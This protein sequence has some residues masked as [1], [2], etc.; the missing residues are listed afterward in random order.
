MQIEKTSAKML[1]MPLVPRGWI[2]RL[3]ALP[4]SLI[5]LYGATLSAQSLEIK[6]VDGRNGRPVVGSAS[7]VNVWVGSERKQAITIPTDS[8]GVARLR[9]TL[10]PVEVNVPNF[11]GNGGSI[12][13]DIPS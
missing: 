10:N 6:L 4:S 5:I 7:Y 9:L 12:V 2:H 13:V 11:S 1:D 3:I 8:N